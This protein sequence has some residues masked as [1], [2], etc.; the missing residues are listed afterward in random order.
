MIKHYFKTAWRNTW[1]NSQFT[2]WGILGLSLGMGVFIAILIYINREHSYDRWDEQLSRV[3][4]I[5]TESEW[6][7]N[8]ELT[9]FSP[10]ALGWYMQEHLPEVEL[11][12]TFR[13]MGEV[14]VKIEDEPFYEHHAIAADSNFF[15]IFSYPFRYGNTDFALSRPDQVVLSRTTAEKWF[16]PADP[17]GRTLEINKKTYTVSGVFEKPGPSHLDI[18]MCLSTSF[19]QDNWN[20]R[21]LTHY[22]LLKPNA[23]LQQLQHKAEEAFVYNFALG[24]QANPYI[25]HT[26]QE[27]LEATIS[28]TE[29]ATKWLAEFMD[30]KNIHL[31]LESV[32]SIHL[33][34]M[35]FGWS[36]SPANHPVLDFEKG[37]HLPVLIFSIIGTLVL[38]L[39]AINYAN[40]AIAIENTQAKNT[41]IRKV[42]G[43]NKSQ[44]IWQ[45]L[46]S[47]FVQ[48]SIALIGALVFS[49]L[50]IRYLNKNMALELEFWNNIAQ[51]TNWQLVVQ[52][53][54]IGLVVTLLSGLYPA[55]IATKFKPVR[56]LSGELQSGQRG[57]G[58]RNT[59]VVFQFV[60][61]LVFIIS[62]VVIRSQL[63]FMKKNDPGFDTEQVLRIDAERVDMD[64]FANLD[65]HHALMNT[66]RAM[67]EIKAL[68]TSH[69]YPGKASH[70][71]Q[72]AAFGPISD[73]LS[74]RANWVGLGYFETLGID[75]VQ[76][77]T[78]S[79]A[80]AS[81]TANAAI[82]N[83]TAAL[84]MG[85]TQPVG[86][87]ISA[88]GMEYRIIGVTH[89]VHL[90]GYQHAIEP[91]LYVIGTLPGMT[92]GRRQLLIRFQ[93]GF[94]AQRS[95]EKIKTLWRDIE[96]GG[97][98]RYAWLQDDFAK[99]M[100]KYEK[101][102]HL[103]T[104]L[105]VIAMIIAAMGIF[106]IS[107][108][109]TQKRIKEIGIR[110]VLGASVSGIVVMLSKEFLALVLV[111]III[112][113]PLAWWAVSKWLEDFAYRINVEW[114]MFALAG[115]LV[116]SIT[117][118]TISGQAIR[119]AMANPTDSLR[120][121]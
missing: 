109:L 113:S 12:T 8:Y 73:T 40:I 75:L 5:N 115:V 15:K 82:I 7:N 104:L 85:L 18:H 1:K 51:T 31:H 39:A 45:S 34:P 74:V 97:P 63:D 83:Q 23:N 32:T 68:G 98:M 117:L 96:K 120:D 119:A 13:E 89:D 38:I 91:E 50:I 25:K 61:A 111:S 43:A 108:F 67:P 42:V 56:L 6:G 37:N 44:I 53:I 2:V 65:E 80:F 95:L 70:S 100:D 28:N 57:R 121:E 14:L 55:F 36:D 10:P 71:I 59:L 87:Q 114:W 81:D 79:E 76:G 93:D 58:I 60:V 41:G 92:G 16:G 54:L 22:V 116:V 101:L 112:A 27:A 20:A 106:A 46:T 62:L 105:S 33:S 52:L 94:A 3:Y 110:K 99:L 102:N 66:L 26:K 118:I 35:T 78:F 49:Y 88:L 64:F 21:V 77:R 69:F 48:V 29:T 9:S 30:I 47:S 17:T 24:Q 107:T 4:R 11:S 103:V 86:E 84:R 72:P 90:A 19:G